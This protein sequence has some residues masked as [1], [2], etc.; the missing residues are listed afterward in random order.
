MVAVAG[1]HSGRQG[2]AGSCVAAAARMFATGRHTVLLHGSGLEAGKGR[3]EGGRAGT[4]SESRAV[5]TAG[6]TGTP[7]GSSSQT[8]GATVAC[9]R[10]SHDTLV[11][12]D[13]KRAAKGRVVSQTGESMRAARAGLGRKQAMSPLRAGPWMTGLNPSVAALTAVAGRGGAGVIP[14]QVVGASARPGSQRLVW[15]RVKV[16]WRRRCSASAVLNWPRAACAG[17]LPGRKL[18]KGGTSAS[19]L[20]PSSLFSP[21]TCTFAGPSSKRS[22]ASLVSFLCCLRCRLEQN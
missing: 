18:R 16:G 12:K 20:R 11:R 17:K 13:A 10:A 5:H 19:A 1:C 2:A 3:A 14:T 6:T 15:R 9:D 4:A 21:S 7:A 22:R 8:A